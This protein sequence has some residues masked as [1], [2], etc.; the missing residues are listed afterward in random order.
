[1]IASLGDQQVHRSGKI[2]VLLNRDAQV[3]IIDWVPPDRTRNPGS[4]QPFDEGSNRA[5]VPDE[6]K[7]FMNVQTRSALCVADLQ[8][9]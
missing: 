9:P 5:E 3:S 7:T 4:D 1:M 2:H 6:K 8:P